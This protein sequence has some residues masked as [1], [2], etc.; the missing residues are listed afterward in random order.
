LEIRGR[1]GDVTCLVVGR[2][3]L[4]I[5]KESRADDVLATANTL[6]EPGRQDSRVQVRGKEAEYKQEM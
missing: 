1:T 2:P 3:L 6:E 5:T 4:Y